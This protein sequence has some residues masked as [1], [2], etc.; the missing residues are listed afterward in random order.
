MLI[1]LTSMPTLSI[2]LTL[3]VNLF[4]RWPLG[5]AASVRSPQAQVAGFM[6]ALRAT[7]GLWWVPHWVSRVTSSGRAAC[8]H[9]GYARG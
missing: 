8:Q 6:V 5:S 7:G 9:P 3:L 1:P 2:V 4:R